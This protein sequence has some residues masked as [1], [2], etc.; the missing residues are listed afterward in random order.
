MHTI[1]DILYHTQGDSNYLSKRTLSRS[2]DQIIMVAPPCNKMLTRRVSRSRR[3]RRTSSQLDS[4]HPTCHTLVMCMSLPGFGHH[5]AVVSLRVV[6]SLYCHKAKHVQQIDMQHIRR[7]RRC[8]QIITRSLKM[9]S[10]SRINYGT[11]SWRVATHHNARRS[12]SQL[13]QL[14]HTAP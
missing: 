9:R 11:T 5:W 1:L 6:N 8:L 12:T 10:A 3:R 13:N 7:H 4:S 14:E 2:V